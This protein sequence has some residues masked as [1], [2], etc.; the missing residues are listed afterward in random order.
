MRFSK[1]LTSTLSLPC[2]N[3]S[4]APMYRNGHRSHGQ[5][6]LCSNE[7]PNSS[8]AQVGHFCDSVDG[9]ARAVLDM[10]DVMK[11]EPAV[12]WLSSLCPVGL[13]I[14]GDFY[15][16]CDIVVKSLTVWI[17]IFFVIMALKVELWSGSEVSQ[18]RARAPKLLSVI[19]PL[20]WRPGLPKGCCF[21]HSRVKSTKESFRTCV[22]TYIVYIY[23]YVFISTKMYACR[24]A[25]IYILYTY[26]CTYVC[27]YIYTHVRRYTHI[28][29]HIYIYT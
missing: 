23:I 24:R 22:R 19:W 5:S 13:H 6:R 4:K 12:A 9:S 17:S 10:L 7:D 8:G 29:V 1:Y 16:F 11:S 21:S 3:P 15:R 20:I 28:G 27:I 14:F 25:Y 2:I 18:G 26:V